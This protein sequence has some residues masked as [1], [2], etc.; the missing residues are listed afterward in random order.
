[1]LLRGV[2]LESVRNRSASYV[3][4]TLPSPF[5][6]MLPLEASTRRR[7]SRSSHVTCDALGDSTIDD[8]YRSP[9]VFVG[10]KREKRLDWVRKRLEIR[11]SVSGS[12]RLLMTHG[13]QVLHVAHA[14]RGHSRPDALHLLLERCVFLWCA[15]VVV[16]G[17]TRRHLR[18]E[19]SWVRYVQL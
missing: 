7:L 16:T 11:S 4:H 18:G 19:P 8:R 2:R 3:V 15:L 10:G 17:A 1:M 9:H 5:A 6:C 12:G 14:S 13:C